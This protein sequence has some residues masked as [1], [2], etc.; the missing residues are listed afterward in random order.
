VCGLYPAWIAARNSSLDPLREGGHQKTPN[1]SKRR[2]QSGLIVAQV[3][4]ATTL[5]LCGGLLIRSLIRVLDVNPGFD[6][7][8]LLTLQIS[9]PPQRFVSPASRLN[10]YRTVLDRTARIPGVAAA[11]GCTLLPFGYGESANTFEVVGRPKAAVEPYANLSTVAAGYFDTMKIPFLGG[12]GFSPDDRIGS[13]PVALID[14]TMAQRYFPDGNP[15][16][17]Q[18]KLPWDKP[19]TI[20]GVVGSVRTSGLEIEGRPTIYFSADQQPSTDLT[21]VI[22]SA[23]TGGAIVNEVERI[24]A[25]VDKD[26]PIYD[27]SSLQTRIDRSIKTRRFVVFLVVI[28]AAAGTVLAS[29][30]LYGL[31]AYTIALRRREI[32]IRMALGADRAAIMSLVYRGGLSLVLAGLVIGCIGAVGLHRYIDSQL[33]KTNFGDYRVW[34]AAIAIV[35]FT[36]VLA[37]AVPALRSAR[38]SPLESLRA[39]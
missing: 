8:N 34:I 20:V 17:H 36:G 15:I 38:L 7:K 25:S 24:V 29:L 21:L 22:R 5:L 11:S 39:E 37:C 12:R 3:A 18:L 33:F 35:G 13:D 16:G 31:L 30:G 2:L 14:Q 32:G 4:V 26:Q 19:F 10:F 23:I 9:L 27:V 1:G 6:A 28:F